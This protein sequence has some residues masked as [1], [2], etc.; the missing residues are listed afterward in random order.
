MCADFAD[1]HPEGPEQPDSIDAL[2]LERRRRSRRL[3]VG[4]TVALLLAGGGLGGV[5]WYQD[6]AA[7]QRIDAAF[8]AFSRCLLGAPLEGEESASLRF[9]A[10]QLSSS[11]LSDADRA[12]E[13]GE[14]WPNRCGNLGHAV[15]EAMR[16]AGR[17]KKEGTDVASWSEALAKA[18][19][20]RDAFL[21]DLSEPIE[22]LWLE[23]KSAGLVAR[24]VTEG[25]P[26]PPLPAP[27]DVGKLGATAPISRSTFPVDTAF[28]E[29]HAGPVLKFL[30]DERSAEGA[31]FVCRY[32]ATDTVI[33][34]RS[35]P[36]SIASKGQ[37]L[38][39]YGT[40]DDAAAPLVFAGNRGDRGIFRADTGE[41]VDALYAYGGYAAADGFTATL[42]FREESK[43]LILTRKMPASPKVRRV[44][45]PS[46]DVG[47]YYYSTQILW[48][49]VA[50][51]AINDAGDRRLYLHEL[52]RTGD[53]LARMSDVGELPEPGMIDGG[54]DEP[55][56][57][58]GCRTKQATVVR[59]KGSYN[60]FLSV[61]VE[62]KPSLPVSPELTGGTLG[63]AG[64]T[65]SV[66]R[67]EPA[68]RESPW[69]TTVSQVLCTTAGCRN[70]RIGVEPML[71]GH[72]EL[73]PREGLVD[74]V[75]LGDQ[76][77]VAWA[78]GE[79]GGV[80]LR[81]G[82][83]ERIE[84]EKDILVFDDLVKDGR[85]QKL[86]T[87]FDL[88]LFAREGFALLLLSTVSGV[89]AVRVEADGRLSPVPAARE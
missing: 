89:F 25:A 87:L 75:S 62:G 28:T 20:E 66:T 1:A 54:A 35:L 71:H 64:T 14:A 9:R 82:T 10:L 76:L 31:P 63:C 18:L 53:P 84:K 65:A 85:L 68:G 34:C 23:A 55:P 83:A 32:A 41:E 7:T 56:H 73:G 74:A 48:D 15:A 49:R 33:T 24:V 45:E 22:N 36:A 42:G 12:V 17:A 3:F 59:V 4:T 46:F 79:R 47:N 6:R 72:Y 26:P 2:A 70:A 88:R 44:I 16:D 69:K 19:K 50:I 52:A 61:L 58:A 40:S 39:L 38:R 11:T 21:A 77:V 57:I 81:V 60:D 37:G 29:P 8:S 86:S 13:N 5:V 80:R 43:E 27:L 51:R 30:V 78:G 67:L